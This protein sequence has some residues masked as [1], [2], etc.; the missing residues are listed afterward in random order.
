MALPASLRRNPGFFFFAAVALLLLG[1]ALSGVVP[2]ADE[3]MTRESICRRLITNSRDGRQALLSSAWW[4]PLPT[5]LRLPLVYL[6]P[7]AAIGVPSHVLSFAFG[8][9]TLTWLLRV[10]RHWQLGGVRYLVAAGVALNPWFIE[11]SLNGSSATLLLFLATAMGGAWVTWETQGRL[12]DLVILGLGSALLTL[13]S[14]EMLLWVALVM[15]FLVL[16]EVLT[17][18]EPHQKEAIFILAFLPWLYALSL[19]VLGNWLIMGD[20]L[21]FLRSL[22][23]PDPRE[24][25]V[26]PDQL[27]AYGVQALPACFAALLF[28]IALF[29]RDLTGLSL[30]AMCAGPCAV[31][32]LLA[33]A[34]W[35]WDPSAALL[36]LPAMGALSVSHVLRTAPPAWRRTKA[37][38]AALPLCVA[39]LAC[40]WP[41]TGEAPAAFP[42]RAGQR[43]PDAL[44]ANARV[45][46]SVRHHVLRRTPFT[47]VYVC[48]YDAFRLLAGQSDPVFVPDLDFDIGRVRREY[49]GHALYVMICRP[50]GRSAMESIHWKFD[51]MYDLGY[52]ATLYDGDWQE[53]RLFEIIDVR[54]E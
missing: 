42:W 7:E 5:L 6:L 18:R 4:A 47:K 35:L 27:L 17:W 40:A 49:P 24:G 31:A 34:H 48:G 41:G 20:G 8:L 16:K 10:L 43:A 9:L 44:Q 54:E 32:L 11:Q 21:Y 19:W 29:R 51:G 39:L 25:V 1:V 53:W 50:R 37:V 45:L 33:R 2:L 22:F 38:L 26:L 23:G 52:E 14:F 28:G 36:P 46:S 13:T 15:A 3:A 30:A 12:T